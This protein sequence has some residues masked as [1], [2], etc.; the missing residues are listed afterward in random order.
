MKKRAANAEFRGSAEVDEALEDVSPV[1]REKILNFMQSAEFENICFDI[2]IA[3]CM[4]G[5]PASHLEE[6]METLEIS[7]RRYIGIEDANTRVIAQA[8]FSEIVAIS[9]REVNRHQKESGIAKRSMTPEI[10]SA[11]IASAARN[12]RI[13]RRISDLSEIDQFSARLSQQC[14][15]VHG[16]I[17]P[18]QTESGTRV[19]FENLY[20]PSNLA[21]GNKNSNREES[22]NVR[23]LLRQVNRL[24]VLGDPGGGKTTLALKLTIDVA[25]GLGTGSTLQAPLRI[26]LREYAA[27]YKS[28]QESIV[29]YLEKQ[30]KADYAT[31]A[32]EGAIEYLLL[33]GRAVVI[34][35]GLDELTDTSLRVAIVDA[36]EAFTHSYPTAPILVTSR[37]VGYEMAPL[38]ESLFTVSNLAPFNQAQ[39]RQY[40]SKWFAHVRAAGD[41][42]RM[43]ER[44]L[45]ES[46]HAEDLTSNPLMLGLMCALY[47]GEGY[48]P[49]NRPDLYR[50]CSEFLFERWDASR[51]IAIAQPF[52]RGIQ[53]AMFSL[54][55]SMLQNSGES[56]GMSERE[57]VRYTSDY[58]LGQQYEDR[59]AADAAAEAFV[60]YCRGR[61]W[62][63]TDVGTNPNGERIYS[64]TH[65]TFLEY[66]SAR[67]LVRNSGDVSALYE[68]LRSHM[69]NESW[70]VTAQ[71]A[72]QFL[73]ERLG[74]AVNEF[75]GLA[76]SDA[77]EMSEFKARAALVSFCARLLEFVTLRPAV[78]RQIVAA[79]YQLTIETK[80]AR[81]SAA[82]RRQFDV[83]AT[84]WSGL[85]VCASET[86]SVA[87]DELFNSFNST[88]RGYDEARFL[89]SLSDCVPRHASSEVR[90]F[91]AKQDQLN[92]QSIPLLP[93]AQQD[94]RASAAAVLFGLVGVVEALSW[95]GPSVLTVQLTAATLKGGAHNAISEL[96]HPRMRWNHR[97][98]ERIAGEVVEALLSTPTPW[99]EGRQNFITYYARLPKG[100]NATACMLLSWMLG[101]E[102]DEGMREE[103]EVK[104]EEE[105][106]LDFGVHD[107]FVRVARAREAK[108]QDPGIGKYR[109]LFTPEF[110]DFIGRWCRGE[111]MLST[112]EDDEDSGPEPVV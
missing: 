26:V 29:E 50:R 78:V 100:K 111:I 95:H 30:C 51:G 28:N 47:R 72:V 67:Q 80:S 101:R 112:A 15:R 98:S 62:V 64:F 63:L 71:L 36:V 27:H 4:P 75:V 55:L 10:V 8:L 77:Q 24:V 32:P 93:L 40:V 42:R 73:D 107:L 102:M 94:R 52:E 85:C 48:I 86:R 45:A 12:A 69:V 31:P 6:L 109:E 14:A 5:N 57:L 19:P 88:S 110:L 70:D 37:R 106:F 34:F 79:L 9:W 90:E 23:E 43:A 61:A 84:A 60:E 25:R 41:E 44:F 56:G 74:D 46:S 16:R 11:Y 39:Q 83:L 65:R 58:L 89:I 87:N 33:N 91:W 81:M 99:M 108:V 3:G 53:F 35:D 13:H 105:G 76:L 38:D 21:F 68:A 104:E 1:D 17:R 7:L 54:A 66:F 82:P 2:A 49:R 22:T 103:G 18:A 92:A 20:V 97:E 59:D 96:A